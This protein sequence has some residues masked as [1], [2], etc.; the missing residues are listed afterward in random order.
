MKAYWGSGAI[1]PHNLN[2]GTRWRCAVSFTL[3]PL[4]LQGSGPRCR[5][6]RRLGRPH[7][8]SGRGGATFPAT[9]GNQ[10][11]VIQPRA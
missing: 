11:P 3:Q 4:Y 6:E 8:R 10:T 1:A 9:A 2:L 5:L 7:S